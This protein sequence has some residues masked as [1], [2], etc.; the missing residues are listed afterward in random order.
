MAHGHDLDVGLG[1]QFT[2][3][4]FPD[5]LNRYYGD[6]LGYTFEF[7]LRVRPSLHNHSAMEMEGAAPS[8]PR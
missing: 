3:N 4:D 5:R 7:F 6:N 2:I 1:T 8:A